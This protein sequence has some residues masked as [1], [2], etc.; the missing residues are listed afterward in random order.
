VMAKPEGT[1]DAE[2]LR[3][4]EEVGGLL[5]PLFFVV[6]G[7]SLNVGALGGDALILLALVCAIACFGKLVPAYVA[8]RVGGLSP[9]DSA[10]VAVLVN[11]RGLT[12]LIALNVGL[13]AGLIDQQVFTVLVLMAVITTLAT[14]PLLSLIRVPA[15]QPSA[16]EEHSAGP[17][18]SAKEP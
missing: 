9:R 7:L 5:L 4:M 3:P 6:T 16:S 10:T 11:T 1:P 15:T 13:S 12:E 2:V 17:P 18:T 8:S 14:A